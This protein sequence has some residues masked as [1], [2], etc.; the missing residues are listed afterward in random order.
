MIKSTHSGRHHDGD[1]GRHP[2][3]HEEESGDDPARHAS[4]IAR[5]WLDSAEPTTERYARTLQQWQALPG[6]VVR[7]AAAVVAPV[8]KRE[9]GG[10]DES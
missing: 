3:G 5:R 4:I 2:D 9:P 10:E 7:P 6:A 1:S 8:G